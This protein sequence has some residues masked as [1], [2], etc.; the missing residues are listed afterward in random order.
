MA[1]TY[2]YPRPAVTV[3]AVV[4]K[5]NS[6]N[7][8]V[9]LIK[10]KNPPYKEK[11]ALPGGFI[12]TD[13]TLEEAVSRELQE[14]TGI[15]GVELQ[16]LYTFSSLERDPRSRTISVVFWGMLHNNGKPKADDD[17]ADAEWFTLNELPPLAFDHAE[18]LHIA[19][20]KL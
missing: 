15:G 6:K 12:D 11:W 18:V 20:K 1:F 13:E 7:T 10:R 8:F 19:M 4:F 17:A 9:L 16:Q 14:E 2:K 5:K 3:D